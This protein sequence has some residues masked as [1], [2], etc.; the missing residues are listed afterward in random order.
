[1]HE[2]MNPPAPR[3][4]RVIIREAWILAAILSAAAVLRTIGISTEMWLD[5]VW[6][7]RNVRSLQRWTDVL[8][9]L[10]TDNNHHLNSLWLYAVRA[11][12]SVVLFR[13][14]SFLC[15]VTTVAFAWAVCK[16]DG[17][18]VRFVA[19]LLFATSYLLAYYSSEARGYE[20]AVLMTL[21]ALYFLQRFGEADRWPSAA[22]F[23]MSSALGVMAHATFIESFIGLF[24]WFDAH[25]QRTSRTLRAGT[26]KT[27]LLFAPPAA[28]IGLFYVLSLRGVGVGGGP[29]FVMTQVIAS[30]LSL[31]GGGPA[32]GPSVWLSGGLVGA[33]LALSVLDAYRHNDDRWVL[34][35]AVGVILPAVF[36]IFRRTEVLFPRYFLVPIAVLLLSA[37]VFVGRLI[38]HGGWRRAMGLLLVS[39]YAYAGTTHIWSLRQHGR[40]EYGVMIATLLSESREP[41][42]TVA[43]A[44]DFGGHDF[45][46][47]MLVD[48]FAQT[49]AGG[50]RLRYLRDTD[51]PREGSLWM[52]RESLNDAPAPKVYGDKYGNQYALA[53]GYHSADL[54]GMTWHLYRRKN[55]ALR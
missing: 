8:V 32:A 22:G 48:Y 39:V 19:A 25:A 36:L 26:R 46:N 5:E 27:A 3:T 49:A 18:R 12:N 16:R 50:A 45:R 43:S 21:M 34:S 11:Y 17:W 15:G 13:A 42:V 44:P 30:T 1:M 33:V 23:W 6:S 47:V 37:S 40:G 55:D 41:L 31:I 29:P 53:G 9:R 52:I 7:V 28:F 20:A 10:R 2:D 4:Q 35:A 54:V 51:Y 14:L 24:V 38:E